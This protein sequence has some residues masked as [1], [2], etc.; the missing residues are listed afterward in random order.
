MIKAVLFDVDGVLLNSF[1]ANVVFFQN[2]LAQAGYPIP[3]KEDLSPIIIH[4]TLKK[5]I[6]ELT[7]APDREVQ[8]I[9]K[10]AERSL[11]DYP[12]QLL[13]MPQNAEKIIKKLFNNYTL[14]IVTSR[15]KDS[16]YGMPQLAKL[17]KYFKITVGV[18]DTKFH[19]PNP[20]PLLF[21]CNKLNVSID[22]TVYIGDTKTDII[23]G[24]MAGMKVILLADKN[25]E[26]AEFYT[27]TF[28]KIPEIISNM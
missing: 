4:N 26:N 25:F 21:A 23:A 16:I 24:K 15:I 22:Q 13:T 19:K 27:S 10:I 18:E 8:R 5:S 1:E 14:G 11:L 17:K 12:F 3:K 7:H 28:E 9:Y 20:E 6:V 2:L